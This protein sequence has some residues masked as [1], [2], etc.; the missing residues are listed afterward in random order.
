M[1]SRYIATVINI[2]DNYTIVVNIG[3]DDGVKNGQEFLVVGIGELL[4]DPNTGEPLEQLEIVRGR[5]QVT[6]VQ[7][8]ITTLRSCDFIR[9]NEKREIT[10]V[11]SSGGGLLTLTM[12][13][14]TTTESIVPAVER[15]RQL[16]GV[17]LGD[18]LIKT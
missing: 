13:Q 18:Q 14:E 6:H 9:E 16:H 15:L 4:R 7:K 17:Q 1:S 8:K 10:R 5:V 3:A 11:R 2:L 12:P